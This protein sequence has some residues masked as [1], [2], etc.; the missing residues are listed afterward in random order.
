MTSFGKENIKVEGGL[1]GCNESE[2]GHF[3]MFVI[4]FKNHFGPLSS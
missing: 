2:C 3:Y 1:R 4:P